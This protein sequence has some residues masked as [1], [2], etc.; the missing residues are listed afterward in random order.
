MPHLDV[1]DDALASCVGCGL[2]LP[3]CPTFR[4]S[5]NEARSP[6]GRIEIMRGI[7]EGRLSFDDDVVAALDSCIQ[8]RG[9]EPACPSGVPYGELI[10]AARRLQR[11]QVGPPVW[12]LRIGLRLLPRRR[13]V[14][15]GSSIVGLLQSVRLAPRRLGRLPVRRGSRLRA[16]APDP[17]IWIFTGCVMDAWFR[18]VHRSLARIL[19]ALGTTYGVPDRGHCCGALHAHAGWSTEAVRRAEHTMTL[20]PGKGPILVDSAGCGAALKD[21]GRMLDSDRARA[22]AARVHDVHEWLAPRL[23]RLE[24]RPAVDRSPVVV[25]D[26]CHLRHVQGVHQSVRTCL[27]RVVDVLE[28]DDDGLCCG[29]GG[30]YSL[31]YPEMA[32]ELRDRKL[33]AIRRVDPSESLLIASANPGCAQHLAATGRMVVHPIEIVA[34]ALP[35]EERR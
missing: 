30:A 12:W 29:A 1:S 21:Y 20:F 24:F 18:P 25:Q 11:A 19:D 34:R 8:C 9:C 31:Q 3:H 28:L 2:C 26:P 13:L 32:A 17:D 35:D 33:A 10:D 22:F 5:G 6:R 23:G 4:I 7:H 15:A 27:A 16:T 14:A